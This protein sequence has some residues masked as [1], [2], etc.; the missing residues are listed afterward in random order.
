[1]FTEV[2][3]GKAYFEISD[4]IIEGFNNGG[5][6]YISWLFFIAGPK[7][8]NL[9]FL[10]TALVPRIF[11]EFPSSQDYQLIQSLLH[12]QFALIILY[13]SLKWQVLSKQNL[14]AVIL[15][16]L[17]SPGFMTVIA[18]PTRHYLTFFSMFLC[19]ISFESLMIKQSL[20][21]LIGLIT[22]I[23]LL[24]F[25]KVALII[26]IAIYFIYRIYKE[27]FSLKLIFAIL[28]PAVLIGIY[29]LYSYT[30]SLYNS[31]FYEK[32]I[33]VMENVY[34]G[35]LLPLYKY[36]MAIVSPFPW[37]K[38]S[39]VVDTIA[40]GGNW[41]L[42]LAYI[43]TA[44]IGLYIFLRM[45]VYNVKIMRLNIETSKLF[46]FGIIMSLS[47]LGGDTG[48]NVYVIVCMPFFA[49]LLL[50]KEYNISIKWPILALVVLNVVV[51]LINN[52]SIFDY[53]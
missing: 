31:S 43:P 25:I 38:Y 45:I 19:F 30:N 44:I 11:Y 12:L 52:E 15:F 5:Y 27:A 29:E 40:Y 37:Y 33:G 23:I 8:L 47:L 49:P 50:I 36:V 51:M 53:V 9:G 20:I 48:F 24:F 3:D 34:L 32:Q 10:P 28:S 35:P 42:L 7:Y 18:Y 21:K 17:I 22:G 4:D 26:F 41:V 13:F 46:L 14:L 39:V 1:M 16:I 2:G 6:N